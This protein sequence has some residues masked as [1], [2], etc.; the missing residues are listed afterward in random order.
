MKSSL[1]PQTLALKTHYFNL[2]VGEK[3][4]P[5]PYFNNKKTK[6]RAG[7]RVLIG[8]GNPKEIEEEAELIALRAHL[9]LNSYT[10]EQL[11]RFLIEHNLGSDCSSYIFYML[12]A[13]SQGKLRKQI[14]LPAKT[15]VLRKML[16][17]IR[18]AE[19]VN[20]R[21]LV[22]DTNSSPITLSKIQAGDIISMLDTGV[23]DRLDHVLLVHE[24]VYKDNLPQTLY[25]S[26]ALQWKAD[27]K[28]NHHVRDGII[29]IIDINTSLIEQS[30]SERNLGNED[31]NE[32]YWRAKTA[33]VLDIRRLHVLS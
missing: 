26:H 16:A 19:N 20:V 7:L 21:T 12:D 27:G 13:E 8:K 24:V 25:Y 15:S 29:E 23:G 2:S 33:Q 6:T 4:L 30:W 28:Y 32:T 10:E 1:S 11:Q 18:T 31:A 17:K 14:K 5:C 3:T 9:D 22:L